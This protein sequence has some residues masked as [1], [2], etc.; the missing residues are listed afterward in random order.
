MKS[1]VYICEIILELKLQTLNDVTKLKQQQQQQMRVLW[2]AG[3]EQIGLFVTDIVMDEGRPT[4][5]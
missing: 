2:V 5:H 1:I 3:C 4:S